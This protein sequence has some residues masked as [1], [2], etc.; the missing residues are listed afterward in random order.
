LALAHSERQG[1]APPTV[2]LDYLE[3]VAAP[4]KPIQV[5][6]RFAETVKRHGLSK[7]VG[8]R[9]AGAF[10]SDAFETA[11]VKYEPSELDKSAIYNEALPLFVERRVA[12]IDDQRLATELRLLERRPRTGGKSDSVDHGPRGQDDAANATAGA[13]VLASKGLD[14][15]SLWSRLAMDAGTWTQLTGG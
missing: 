1:S 7:V 10:S 3:C 15:Q 13:L 8:D 9:Y 12:L 14:L 5:A 4:H 6:A 2:V 11:G